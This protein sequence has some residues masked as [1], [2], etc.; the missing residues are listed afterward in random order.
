MKPLRMLLL[1]VVI[2]GSL[3]ILLHRHDVKMLAVMLP[4]LGILLLFSA[5]WRLM[6]WKR[7][8]TADEIRDRTLTWWWMVAIFFL[9]IATHR[10]VSFLFLGFLCF[11]SLREYFSLLPAEE[12]DSSKIVPS[13]D[14]ASALLCYLSIPAVIYIAYIQWYE[15]FIIFV[16][17]YLVLLLPIVFVLEN[18]T[19][20]ALKSLAVLSLGLLFFVH[21][22]GH[23]LFMINFGA[24]L[25]M[26]CFTL[27]E[28]RDLA[29]YWI[30]KSFAKIAGRMQEGRWRR[31]MEAKIAADVS[32]KKTWSAGLCAALLIAVLSLAFVPLMPDFP[33]RRLS[34]GYSAFVG[35]MIGFAGLFGDLVFSMIK[36]DIGVKDSGTTLPGHGGIIDRVDSLVFTTPITFHLIY[37]HCF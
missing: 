15:L 13:K 24:M 6:E 8:P 28:V 30:G 18:R 26:Y 10:I 21:N 4:L 32:P 33:G 27:T 34:Y 20:G 25:L 14:R 16:P 36:R 7:M 31:L 29:S 12:N 5:I 2:G 3:A 17:V 1:S 37:W 35:F 23:C 22:L 19:R 9:A 11:A